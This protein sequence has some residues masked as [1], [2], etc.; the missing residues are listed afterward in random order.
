[1]NE[2]IYNIP[3]FKVHMPESVL[4]PLNEVLMSGF[5]GQGPK[6]E[7]FE[8][9]IG[10]FIG[11]PNVLTVNSGTSAIQ[12]A[13]RLAGV[14]I[15]DEVI[16]TPMT[17]IATNVPIIAAG[18]KIKWA[19]IDSE[20]GSLSPDS[21]KKKISKKTKAIM[22]MQWGGYPPNMDEIHEIAQDFGI[23]VIE[24]AA[25]GFGA[26][27]KNRKTGSYSDFTI[28]SFQAIKHI[29]TGDG[30]ALICRNR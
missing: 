9:K 30:G 4:K 16:T 26:E 5:I 7:E 17:N 20:T 28:F 13:Y 25:Q 22:A 8:K 21:V 6:V 24:D 19:D 15:G 3:L 29:T 1:M 10:D 14:G 11:N 12:L 23:K 18:G 27:Y 2:K